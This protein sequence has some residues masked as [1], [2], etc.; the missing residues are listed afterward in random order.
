MRLI[1]WEPILNVKDF[2]LAANSMSCPFAKEKT[3]FFA[4]GRTALLQ[5]LKVLNI[6]KGE[7]VLLPSY[8]CNVVLAPFNHLDIEI[9]YFQVDTQLNPRLEQIEA[10]IDKNTRAVLAVNYFGFSTCS[11]EIKKIC[12]KHNLFFIEDNAHGF[13]SSDG[14]QPLG[15]SGDISIFSMRKMLGTPNGAALVINNDKLNLDNTD[16]NL[17]KSCDF[18]Y[19]LR[20]V[21]QYLA[22]FTGIDLR[23][24]LKRLFG[25]KRFIP[26]KENSKEEYSIKEYLVKQSGLTK[27]LMR[28]VKIQNVAARRRNGFNYWLKH[29]PEGEPVFTKLTE[30]IVPYVFPVRTADPDG[31]C[32]RMLLNRIECYPW[33]V[34]PA[35]LKGYPE[36]YGQ[37]VT[38]PLWSNYGS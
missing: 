31:F 15:T 12:Q 9:K 8:I 4:Y 21:N 14:N 23:N 38:I 7:N 1:N 30:G 18:L 13:L 28:R 10:G 5:A 16:L 24:A 29:L 26:A 36:F 22:F 25:I 3:L 20:Q 34:L 6:K 37:I 11:E 17:S 32:R 2:S 33:P 27:L 35:C 19:S